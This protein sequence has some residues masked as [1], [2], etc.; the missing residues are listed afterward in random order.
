MFKESDSEAECGRRC[1]IA[2]KY[3]PQENYLE[4]DRRVTVE[5]QTQ[6]FFCYKVYIFNNFFY[7]M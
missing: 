4:N 1:H 6:I 2:L 7:N 5:I 3:L